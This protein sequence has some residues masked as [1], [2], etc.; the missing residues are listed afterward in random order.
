MKLST[1]SQYAITAILE[2]ALK[3]HE[4]AVTLL[5]IA[6]MED[7]SLSYLEQLFTQLRHH[8][9]VKGRRGPGGGYTLA[10]DPGKITIAEIVNAVDSKSQPVITTGPDNN[11]EVTSALLWQHLSNQIQAYMSE[12]TVADILAYANSANS[13]SSVEVLEAYKKLA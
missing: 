8:K 2:L 11:G 4:K 13:G 1:R 3:Q 12:I 6:K 5:E 7:I 9:L 10:R